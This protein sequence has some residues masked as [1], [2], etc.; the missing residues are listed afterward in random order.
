MKVK[1]LKITRKFN[2]GRNT[3]E[4][5]DIEVEFDVSKEK[6]TTEEITQ[7]C[8]IEY[9]KIIESSDLPQNVKDFWR[10]RQGL[11]NEKE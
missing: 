1:T 8:F 4:N 3:F 10:K 7:G 11:Y 9:H 5:E 6:G 2:M